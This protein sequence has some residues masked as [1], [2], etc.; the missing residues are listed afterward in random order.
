MTFSEQICIIQELLKK[1]TIGSGNKQHFND[2]GIKFDCRK[3]IAKELNISTGTLN[4]IIYVMEYPHLIQLVED[5]RISA[6]RAYQLIKENKIYDVDLD[7]K[8]LYIIREDE[9]DRYKIGVTHNLTGRMDIH[10]RNNPHELTYIRLYQFASEESAVNVET[11]FKRKY[12]LNR[13]M[14]LN[15]TVL[16]EWFKFDNIYSIIEDIDNISKPYNITVYQNTDQI[17]SLLN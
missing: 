2:H 17:N 15:G 5:G 13:I 4:H 11:L 6:S 9:S 8:Y 16:K 3:L 10:S 7:V 12:K 14:K 1:H